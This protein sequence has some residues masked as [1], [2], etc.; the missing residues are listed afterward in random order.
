MATDIKQRKDTAKKNE[1]EKIPGRKWLGSKVFDDVFTDDVSL[2]TPHFKVD[3]ETYLQ[4]L[5]DASPEIKDILK[6]SGGLETARDNIYNYLDKAERKVFAIDNN[7][8]ILEKST[9]RESIRVFRSIIGP[10]NE[11]RTDFSALDILWKLANDKRSELKS[12]ISIGSSWSLLISSEVLS[13]SQIFTRK[14]KK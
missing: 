2:F 9:V 3:Y 13:V 12:E 4:K 6:N 11:F 8:H 7:L 5:W 10:I 14:M 1:T